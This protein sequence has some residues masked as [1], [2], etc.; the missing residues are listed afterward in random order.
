MTWGLRVV[1]QEGVTNEDVKEVACAPQRPLES[2]T[3]ESPQEEG[4]LTNLSHL[5]QTPGLMCIL[6]KGK[7]SSL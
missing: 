6:G 4:G 7:G 2:L 5:P 1:P 3:P